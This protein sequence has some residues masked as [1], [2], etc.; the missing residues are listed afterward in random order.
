[1]RIV[2]IKGIEQT[3][4]KVVGRTEVPTFE[5]TTRQDAQPQRDLIEPRAVFGRTVKH[6]LMRRIAE[7]G[8]PLDPPAK[9]LGGVGDSAPLRHEAADIE[10]PGR[11]EMIH[12]PIV[13]VHGGQLPHDVGQ[14]G[15]TILAGAR[16]PEMPHQL[17]W[18]HHERGNQAPHAM[19]AVLLRT[20]F[21]LPRLRGLRGILPLQHLHA[22][23]FIRAEHQAT[24]LVEAQGVD[25]K[26]TNVPRLG[27]KRGGVAIE[28]IHTAMRLEVRFLQNP[29]EARAT[30]EPAPMV[31]TQDGQHVIEAPACGPAVVSCGLSGGHRQDID[32]LRGGKSAVADPTAAHP[33]NRRAHA[34]DIECAR[35][36]RFGGDRACRR[37][38]GDVGGHLEPPHVRSVDNARPTPGVWNG[39]ARGTPNV[40]VRRPLP[41]P[42]QQK[43]RAWSLS[44]PGRRAIG[45]DIA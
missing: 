6:R 15:G 37:P 9:H 28:P 32:L 39:H 23:L 45:S 4:F 22:G 38:P 19:A 29:P 43:A 42:H 2:D 13:A 17:P 20:F 21:W 33:A 8:P 5:K 24:F 18:G 35:G 27:C 34:R 31:L 11:L 41:S 14:M 30:H 12:H 36:G 40:G 16:G 10:A 26:L 7:E 25:I 44:L 3:G 1:M